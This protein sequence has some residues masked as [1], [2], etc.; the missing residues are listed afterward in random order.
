L[1]VFVEVF[2]VNNDKNKQAGKRVAASYPFVEGEIFLDGD[3]Y[4]KHILLSIAPFLYLFVKNP[5][6]VKKHTSVIKCNSSVQKH[7]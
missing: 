6:L 1:N 3:V 7:E 2:I 4:F 5:S